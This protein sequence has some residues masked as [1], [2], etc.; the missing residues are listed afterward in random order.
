MSLSILFLDDKEIGKYFLN[1]EKQKKFIDEN[2]FDFYIE[3]AIN[4]GSTIFEEVFQ[5]GSYTSI[6]DIVDKEK[7]TIKEQKKEG[8]IETR[9]LSDYFTGTKTINLYINEIEMD[10]YSLSPEHQEII[11]PILKDLF[12]VHELYHH[13]EYFSYGLTSTTMEKQY[14]KYTFFKREIIFMSLSEIAAFI[15]T[16]KY[17]N[18]WRKK[19]ESL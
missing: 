13:F 15:F 19:S 9:V 8:L 3:H 2:K 11:S 18:E 7:I 5:K 6:E 14:M 10:F 1:R 17:I 4:Q 16:K 12:I